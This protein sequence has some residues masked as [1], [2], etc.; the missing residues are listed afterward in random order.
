MQLILNL[1][2]IILA[3]IDEKFKTEFV[4]KVITHLNDYF[5]ALSDKD[6]E[7]NTMESYLKCLKYYFIFQ[8]NF[9]VSE[10][11]TVIDIEQV[12]ILI[13]LKFLSCRMFQRKYQGIKVLSS[14][15]DSIKEETDK[16]K[17][18]KYLLKNKVLD[19]LFVSGYH[20]EVAQLSEPVLTFLAPRLEAPVLLKLLDSSFAQSEEKASVVCTTIKSIISNLD[21]NVITFSLI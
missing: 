17:T 18:R 7:Y 21:V 13:N 1:F 11:T 10:S 20:R 16:E 19:I 15:L 4:D 8:S 3:K 9:V 6:I 12:A 2:R 5:K 14:R